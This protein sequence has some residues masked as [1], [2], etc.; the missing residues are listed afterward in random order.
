M[1]TFGDPKGGMVAASSIAK[2]KSSEAPVKEDY[3]LDEGYGNVPAVMS[4]GHDP[5]SGGRGRPRTQVATKGER[6]GMVKKS[7]QDSMKRHIADRLGKHT[8]ANLPEEQIDEL[9]GNQHRIDANKNKRIDSE[10]FRLLRARKKKMD[11]GMADPNDP[12]Y[13]GGGDVTS[14]PAAPAKKMSMPRP[15][16]P[17]TDSSVQGSGDVTVSGKPASIREAAYSAKAARAGKDIGKPGKMFSKIASK[18]GER[19]GSE[20]RGKKVAGAILKRIRAKHMKE[21]QSF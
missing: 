17:K 12:S 14:T 18:A 1:G 13:Q 20:E 5:L 21:D 15:T 9:V 16:A 8:K 2:S 10:D 7:V 11:E 3:D 19:Y 6:K 4:L